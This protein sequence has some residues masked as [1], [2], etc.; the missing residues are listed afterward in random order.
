MNVSVGEIRKNITFR[1]INWL[2]NN[3]PQQVRSAYF[4][5]TERKY[6]PNYQ[7]MAEREDYL[8]AYTTNIGVG[9]VVDIRATAKGN[10]QFIITDLEDNEI[11]RAE[12][13]PEQKHVDSLM[14][15]PNVLQ[16]S[17]EFWRQYEVFR[18]VFGNAFMYFSY[19]ETYE[20]QI[21]QLTSIT[22]VWSQYMNAVYTGQYF[23]AEEITD[24]IEKYVLQVQ[25]WSREF[26]TESILHR[27]DVSVELDPA[28]ITM[29]VSKLKNLKKAISNIDIA[30]DS[31]NVIGRKRGLLGLFTPAVSDVTGSV[32]MTNKQKDEVNE[33]F[34]KYG[35][36]DHQQQYLFNKHPLKFQKT[37]VPMKDL[38]LFE[39]VS[40]DIMHIANKYQVP[41]ILVKTYLQG[42]TFENQQASER[43]LYETT[44][45]PETEDD[46]KALNEYLKLEE[47]GFK[48]KPTFDHIAVL[49]EDLK[50]RSETYKNNGDTLE[51]IFMKGGCTMGEW[52][53]G[54]GLEVSEEDKDKTI[55]DLTP[56]QLEVLGIE[57]NSNTGN[58]GT[59]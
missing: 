44:I 59:S 2:I 30:F 13:T 32:P 35:T 19:P 1:A 20:G 4:T 27:N 24:I 50:N 5:P 21:L 58:N 15:Q 49:Q 9:A 16:S 31:R 10:V 45:I 8:R 55:F 43:R 36:L 51:A 40:T 28:N 38:M 56:E 57:V 25:N 3:A 42:A 39:E 6:S 54:I 17:F 47:Y 29:G 14:K 11:P 48:V 46:I 23:D 52:R 37:S 22:N 41:E 26:K 7:S 53:K 12:M 18:S 34:A 33:E